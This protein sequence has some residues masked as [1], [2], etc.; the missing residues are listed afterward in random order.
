MSV[1]CSSSQPARLG[2]KLTT[3]F[4]GSVRPD[5]VVKAAEQ[6]DVIFQTLLPPR[7]TYRAATQIRRSLSNREIEPFNKGCVQFH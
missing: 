2:P 6:L 5:E 7:L 1:L 3:E 4:E